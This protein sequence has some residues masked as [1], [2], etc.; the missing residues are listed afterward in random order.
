MRAVGTAA[1]RYA[2]Y[3]DGKV[4]AVATVPQPGESR[5]ELPDDHPDL[6]PPAP[7]ATAG[8]ASFAFGMREG[9]MAGNGHGGGGS[10]SGFAC[11]CVSDACRRTGCQARLSAMTPE[12][13][14]ALG[15]S[16]IERGRRVLGIDGD[17][18]RSG[19]D[20]PP[21][22]CRIRYETIGAGGVS[23]GQPGCGAGGGSG[24]VGPP[25]RGG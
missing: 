6:A 2:L 21:G 13:R 20:A 22:A 18:A 11:G 23:S 15:W 24:F 16:L 7:A 4:V 25:G 10:S 5:V 14:Q 19:F 3:K 12:Q 1:V 8:T 9:V 17:V